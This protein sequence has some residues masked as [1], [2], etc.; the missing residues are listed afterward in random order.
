MS[1][2]NSAGG[3]TGLILAALCLAVVAYAFHATSA[4]GSA[5]LY[6]VDSP[7]TAGAR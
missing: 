1:K 5:Q 3:W 7:L 4:Q 2:R 6:I